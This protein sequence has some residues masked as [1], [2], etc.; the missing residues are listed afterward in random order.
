MSNRKTSYLL[1]NIRRQ[2]F[3]NLCLLLTILILSSILFA[4]SVISQSLNQGVRNMER[5]LGAD[6]MFV[7]KGS[8]ENA[9]NM[10]LEGSRSS[11]YFDDSIFEKI[12]GIDG[13]SEITSQCF[14][15]SLSADCCSSEVQI[16]FFDPETDFVVGPWIETEYSK[17]LSQDQ[18]IVGSSITIENGVIRLFGKEYPV[19][20]QMAK[21]GTALDSSVYFSSSAKSDVLL[22]AE[23]KGSFLTEE[24]KK[25]EILS[26][27]FVNVSSDVK[28]EKVIETAHQ[29]VGDIFDVVYPKQLNTSLA[30]SLSNITGIV[31][32]LSI[33][34]TVLLFLILLL[35]SSL[36][37]NQRKQ[38]VALFRILGKTKRKLAL[39]LISEVGAVSLA[40]AVSGCLLSAL[41]VIPFGTFIGRSFS[42][43]YLGP[44]TLK[45]LL[46]VGVISSGAVIIS[47]LTSV[48]FI[49]KVTNIQPYLALRREE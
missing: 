7:P 5:R 44:G 16:V 38:E 8:K 36:I 49:L 13:I 17:K 34:L 29:T 33:S 32:I 37:M 12:S 41:I 45:T 1:K 3:Y 28:L 46:L 47:F 48:F 23:E 27:V 26:S 30:G 14:L 6:I 15:K 11:F 25:G 43:P 18:V 24:Q 2:R 39:A 21:T 40:G 9:E 20:S 42:M 35:I 22:H 10:L 19:V 31:R 4:A